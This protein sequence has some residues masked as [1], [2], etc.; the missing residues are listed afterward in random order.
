ML[1]KAYFEKGY[2]FLS[3]PKW[4]IAVLGIGNVVNKNYLIVFVG[5]FLFALLCFF[6]GWIVFKF[7]FFEA[8]QE[9]SNQFNYF[10]REVREKI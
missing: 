4:V 5:A 8:E 7:G 3:Y 2:S 1:L 6:V 9:V 10:V